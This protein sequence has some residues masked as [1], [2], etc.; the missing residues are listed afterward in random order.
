MNLLERTRTLCIPLETHWKLQAIYIRFFEILLFAS[1]CQPHS[2]KVDNWLQNACSHMHIQNVKPT[3]HHLCLRAP[4]P[5]PTI[6]LFHFWKP[7]GLLSI[8]LPYILSLT[9]HSLSCSLLLLL[10]RACECREILGVGGQE[11]REAVRADIRNMHVDMMRQF[12]LQ[13][14]ELKVPHPLLRA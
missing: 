14:R 4:Q 12:H 9:H 8:T 13:Q 3:A 5:D 11:S 10:W 2:A 1:H 6:F 7:V